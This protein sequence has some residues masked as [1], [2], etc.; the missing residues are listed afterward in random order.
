MKFRSLFALTLLGVFLLS[1]LS[2]KKAVEK[3]YDDILKKLMAD[4]SWI[5]TKFTENSND[6]TPSFNGW[7]CKFNDNNTMTA[8]Q[9]AGATATVHSGTWQSNITAQTITAQ[10]TSSVGEPLSKINGTWNITNTTATVGSFSQTK[11]GVAYTME[12]TKY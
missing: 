6:I 4:G 9:G 10:F 5:I 12:L 11:G 1:S 8:T 3:Q 2:C 7:V